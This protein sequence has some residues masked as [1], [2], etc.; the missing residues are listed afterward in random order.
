MNSYWLN[1]NL[2]YLNCSNMTVFYK[3]FGANADIKQIVKDIQIKIGCTMLDG[4]AG[5]ET[6][7]K[8]KQYQLKHNL[9]V[10]GI[11]GVKTR[12]SLYN[13]GTWNFPHFKRKEFTCNCGCGFDNIDP[14]IVSILED[15]RSHFGDKPII[16]TSGCRCERYNDSLKGSIKGSKHTKGKAVDFYIKGKGKSTSVTEVL[17][18][19]KQLVKQGKLKYTYTNNTNMKG[20]VHI[21]I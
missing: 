18:Y 12:A 10:D 17:S 3:T 5:F 20:A 9:V 4:L 13:S 2:K 19:C 16:V 15:I 7:R 21:N 11:A 8:T 1:K 14:T 6:I